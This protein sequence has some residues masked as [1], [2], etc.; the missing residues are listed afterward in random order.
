MDILEL[1][2]NINKFLEQYATFQAFRFVLAVYLI[3][4]GFNIVLMLYIMI[5]RKG[6][7]SDFSFGRGVPKVI[8][9]MN[10]R[11]EVLAEVII[12]GD[13]NNY[14]SAIVEAGDMLYETLKKIGY[15]GSNLTQQLEQMIG[16]QI[17][18]LEGV[19]DANRIRE[20]ILANVDYKISTEKTREVMVEFGEALKE[21]EAIDNILI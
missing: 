19:K 16:Y 5:T 12:N 10:K 21:M 17:T 14:K 7:W 6:Y 15:P 11:W 9:V 4:I 8:G 3:I 20:D 1:L 2:T 18:N 13:F